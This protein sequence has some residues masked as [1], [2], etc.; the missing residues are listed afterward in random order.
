ML[1]DYKLSILHVHETTAIYTTIE[2][3]I[4]IVNFAITTTQVTQPYKRTKLSSSYNSQ[5]YLSVT[6]IRFFYRSI[7]F[8]L[9][10]TWQ[11]LRLFSQTM[12]KNSHR[13]HSFTMVICVAVSIYTSSV[14]KYRL[15]IRMLDAS[16]DLSQIIFC[17]QCNM[18]LTY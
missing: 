7:V 10:F 8:Y 6:C 14:L 13:I 5:L 12:A 17:I 1:L 18:A 11:Q 16:M 9:L 15:G 2:E 3:G 4:A